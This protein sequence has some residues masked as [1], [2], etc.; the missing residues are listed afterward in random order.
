MTLNA[1]SV[2]REFCDNDNLFN[3]LLAPEELQYLISVCAQ[4]DSNRQNLPYA[5]QLLNNILLQFVEQENSFFKDGDK[6]KAFSVFKPFISDICYNCLMILRSPNDA[7]SI[8]E[9]QATTNVKKLGIHRI[10]AIEQLRTLLVAMSKVVPDLAAS[11]LISKVL[12][13]KIIET[14]LYL[15]KA[16]PFCSISHQQGLVILNYL[17]ELF[18]E[19]DLKTLKNFVKEIFEGDTKFTF[20]SGLKASGMM[21]G[22]VTKIAFEL[23]NMTQKELDNM[24]SDQEEDNQDEEVLKKSIEIA[25]W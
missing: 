5:L 7:D 13:R 18:D 24:D 17:K 15:I 6:A 4:F 25:K 16:Y 8:F 2:L 23:R 22:Q 9:N 3:L 20:P 14:I 10:R 12:R 21:M 19:E 11:G 1:S